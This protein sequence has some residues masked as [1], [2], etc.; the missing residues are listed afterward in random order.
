MYGNQNS[1][2]KWVSLRRTRRWRWWW[3]WWWW[4]RSKNKK[5][6]VYINSS[7]KLRA[8][9]IEKNLKKKLKKKKTVKKNIKWKK[10][11]IEVFKKKKKLPTLKWNKS[12]EF[13]GNVCRSKDLKGV[14]QSKQ[15][16]RKVYFFFSSLFIFLKAFPIFFSSPQINYRYLFG[17]NTYYIYT[18]E[19][20]HTH[21]EITSVSMIHTYTA[22]LSWQMAKWE[23]EEEAEEEEGKKKA[24]EEIWLPKINLWQYR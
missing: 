7:I 21:T 24:K 6:D 10:K 22:D 18:T 15:K 13:W 19:C 8:K 12:E 5:V 11:E 23:E 14:G 3:W 17:N 9:L 4:K 20:T 1:S 2:A 16:E